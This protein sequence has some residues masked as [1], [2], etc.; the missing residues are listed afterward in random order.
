MK[1]ILIFTFSAALFTANQASAA[2]IQFDLLGQGGSGLRS[3]NELG[4]IV[5]TPGTGGEVGAGISFDDVT[6]IITINVGWGLAD[7]FTGSL[8]G[9]SSAMHIHGPATISQNAG[10]LLGLDS[11]GGYSNIANG[12]GFN[13]NVALNPAQEANLLAGLLYINVHTASNGGGEIRGNIVPIPEPSSMLLA[14]FA[15]LTTLSRRRR[16]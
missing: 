10:V 14:S 8:T 5:G 4:A 7:G 15:G 13:G 1:Y 9:N 12:G 6:K 11:L 2:V 3:T 16:D